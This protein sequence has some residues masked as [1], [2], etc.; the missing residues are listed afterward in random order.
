MLQD[1]SLLSMGISHQKKGDFPSAMKD[2][3]GSLVGASSDIVAEQAYFNMVVLSQSFA[4]SDS[5]VE[6]DLDNSE[7]GKVEKEIFAIDQLNLEILSRLNEMAIQNAAHVVCLGKVTFAKLAFIAFHA[8]Y[9]SSAI[10]SDEFEDTYKFLGQNKIGCS[11]QQIE[12]IQR[13]SEPASM[14]SKL[15]SGDYKSNLKS[16]ICDRF[17]GVLDCLESVVEVVLGK[18]EVDWEVSIVIPNLDGASLLEDLFASLFEHV[19]QRQLKLEVIVIDHNS[20]DNS[21]EVCQRYKNRFDLRFIN[22][23]RNYSFSSSCNLGAKKAKYS[24]LLFLN[25]DIVFQSDSISE[26]LKLF[27]RSNT[28]CVGVRMLNESG[29]IVHNGIEFKW[30]DS[31]GYFIPKN[32]IEP[33]S[34]TL[35][36]VAVTGAHL[37]LK[38]SDFDK[39]GG[40][41]ESFYY[42]LEDVDLCLRV[43]KFLQKR[44]L[45]NENSKVVHKNEVTRMRLPRVAFD[46]ERDRNHRIFKSVWGGVV[47]NWQ[48]ERK[49]SENGQNYQQNYNREEYAGLISSNEPDHSQAVS[50]IDYGYSNEFDSYVYRKESFLKGIFRCWI[51]AAKEK[52]LDDIKVLFLVDDNILGGSK[53]E[54]DRPD[55]YKATGRP[56]GEAVFN[57]PKTYLDGKPHDFKVVITTAF[58]SKVVFESHFS[59]K[60]EWVEI[61]ETAELEGKFVILLSSHNLKVQGAQTSL[62]QTVIGLKNDARLFPVVFSPVDGPLRHQYEA[63]GIPVIIQSYPRVNGQTKNSWL[64]EFKYFVECITALQPKVIVANTLQSYQTAIAGLCLD[65]PTVLV[66]RES[67]EPADYFSNLPKYLRGYADSLVS[68]VDQAVFVAK[69]TQKLWKH[70]NMDN[71]RV[72][73]NGLAISELEKKVAGETKESARISFGFSSNDKVILSVGTVCERKGQLDLIRSIPS[74]LRNNVEESIKFV[75]VG[76]NDNEY[77]MAL[78]DAVSRFP[79]KVQESVFLLPQTEQS[80]DTLVQKLLLASDLFVISSIYESYPRVVLEALY[81]GLP[82]IATPCFGVLEQIDDGKSGFF[83]QEGNYHDLSEKICTLVCDDRLLEQHSNEAYKKFESLTSYEDMVSE[84]RQLVLSLAGHAF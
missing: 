36:Q 49:R 26:S 59:E 4:K 27:D 79:Q 32:I 80:N 55:V 78:K 58:A 29:D 25:N 6:I 73:Y 40:F 16:F 24:N 52:D 28:G 74:I 69:A 33:T 38:K 60:S 67:E 82:V 65:M 61:R 81:F 75:I 12:K 9:W 53:I 1:R 43:V 64:S 45:L 72:I 17:D 7:F 10:R 42:G 46:A 57:I 37:L 14:R 44:V 34:S 21:E 50:F 47:N 68:S 18:R 66:P 39:V 19:D 2:F 11:N 15:T 31:R 13:L 63:N 5:I 62:F 56:A 22:R 20:S 35:N 54:F 51:S 30:E 76:M 3:S 23:G 8:F 83:Y 70:A 71:Q 48:H 41:D 84:Y 77:S